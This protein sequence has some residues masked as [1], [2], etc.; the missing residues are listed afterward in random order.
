VTL[1]PR[2]DSGY[3]VTLIYLPFGREIT[4]TEMKH[5]FLLEIGDKLHPG[6]LLPIDDYT[7]K[8]M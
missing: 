3:N 7:T 2:D 6:L 8:N 1:A 4:E 5:F